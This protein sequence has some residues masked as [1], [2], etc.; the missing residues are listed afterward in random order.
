MIS[1]KYSQQMTSPVCQPTTLMPSHSFVVVEPDQL[2]QAIKCLQPDQH[3]FHWSAMPVHV[4]T[5]HSILAPHQGC[6]LQIKHPSLGQQPSQVLS[7]QPPFHFD[8]N[9]LT[10]NSTVLVVA[11]TRM[12]CLI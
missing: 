1:F 10:P 4:L 3:R 6:T 9:P 5:T 8:M 7:P 11:N 2:A 12:K